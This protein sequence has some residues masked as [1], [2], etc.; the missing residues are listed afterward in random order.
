MS[1]LS[2]FLRRTPGEALREYFDRPEIG[3]TT[4]LDWTV[5]EG[6]LARPLLGAIEDMSR[7][8]RDRVSNDAE[9][10]HALSDEPG[11]A[12]IY[13]VAE[14]PAFLD[15]LANP[16]ARSLWMFLNAQDR[17]RHAEEV[18]FTEDRRRGRMWA[19][20]VTDP[21]C[22]L[23][24][25]AA[26]REAFIAAVKEFS[27]AAHAYVDIFERVRTTLE[28]DVCDLVQVTVY[29]EGSPNDLLR[30]DDRGL[31]IRQA[32]RPVFEAAVTYEP[33]TGAIEVIASDQNT[34][35]E[36]LKATFA[37]LLGVEFK[38]N[39]L[40]LRRYDLSVLLKPFDF[41]VDPEDG[42]EGV[43]V[44]ELRVMPIDDSDF[45]VT[46]DKPARAGETIW[47]KAEERFGDHTPL[48]D[49]YVVTRAK[50]AVKL[51]RPAGGTGRRS[52][53]LSISWPHGCDLKDRTATEQ[54]IGEKYLRRWGILV[55]DVQLF[56]D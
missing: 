46:L 19:G 3:L 18:R 48:S 45:R 32:Y 23:L 53:T 41:P 31:L 52:L 1:A 40:P 10:V 30:F 21:G 28:G 9:R 8:Q 5:S 4:K 2:A 26:A 20:F 50:I 42:I 16:H 51:A 12:A 14:D 33:A 25:D 35:G 27:G 55:D 13:S 36:I 24:R 11:Q 38:E 47:T 39:R 49:G 54:L 56:E 7:E 44:R 37:H 15:G 34:R 43:D 17:F 6:A 22:A 29:R